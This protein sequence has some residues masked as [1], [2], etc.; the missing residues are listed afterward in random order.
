MDSLEKIPQNNS[1][2]NKNVQDTCVTSINQG[3]LITLLISVIH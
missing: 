1:A 2:K 3:L